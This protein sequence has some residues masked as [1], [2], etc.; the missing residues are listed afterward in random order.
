VSKVYVV[1]GQ[2][3][4]YSDRTEW[5][6][7]AYHDEARAK[8]HATNAGRRAMTLISEHADN[9]AHWDCRACDEAE[10]RNYYAKCWHALNEYDP[11][12]ISDYNGARYRVFS[13]EVV[14]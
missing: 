1:M 14:P 9:A 2:T 12:M 10:E 3:G 11:Q 13:V 4:E 8:E 6:V 7:V 5:P